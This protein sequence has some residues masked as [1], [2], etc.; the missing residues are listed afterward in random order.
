MIMQLPR[1]AGRAPPD[2]KAGFYLGVVMWAL[3]CGKAF[4]AKDAKERKGKSAYPRMDVHQTRL[5]ALRPFARKNSLDLPWRSF[6]SFAVKTLFPP[7]DCPP[8]RQVLTVFRQTHR[9]GLSAARQTIN[10]LSICFY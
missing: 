1:H 4:T 8:L 9:P 3:G 10:T 6:A 5:L 2:S 7:V